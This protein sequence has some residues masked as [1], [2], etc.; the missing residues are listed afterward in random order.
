M[1]PN[2][3]SPLGLAAAAV[4][5]ARVSPDPFKVSPTRMPVWRWN[6]LATAWH[7]SAWTLQ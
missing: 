1:P 3:T 6:S 7:H 2:Q 5:W 4:T